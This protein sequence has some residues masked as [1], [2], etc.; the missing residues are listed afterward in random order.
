VTH[1][2]Q[3]S[4]SVNQPGLVCRN[5]QN[6]KSMYLCDECARK[7]ELWEERAAIKEFLGGMSRAESERLTSEEMGWKPKQ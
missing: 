2:E 7:L 3:S 5:C 6:G 1:F 4:F